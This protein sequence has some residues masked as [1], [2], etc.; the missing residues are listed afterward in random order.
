ML[1]VVQNHIKL[2]FENVYYYPRKVSAGT[3]DFDTIYLA[4]EN[5]RTKENIID[6]IRKKIEYN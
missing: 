4:L 2:I 3:F 5:K 6:T 1:A